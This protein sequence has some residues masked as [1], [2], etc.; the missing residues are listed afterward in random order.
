VTEE[1]QVVLPNPPWALAA[2]DEILERTFR[3]AE[4]AARACDRE[5]LRDAWS[6][7]EKLLLAHVAAEEEFLFPAFEKAD[8]AEAGALR[9]EHMSLR[10][11]FCELGVGV[12]LH[13]VGSP[14]VSQFIADLRRHAEREKS[15]AF[16]WAERNLPREVRHALASALRA[17]PATGH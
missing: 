4:L 16:P 17:D 8:A 2:G 1:P 13:L 11:Q 5:G 15:L 12:D 14:L 6:R 7:L 10:R 9:E 3:E